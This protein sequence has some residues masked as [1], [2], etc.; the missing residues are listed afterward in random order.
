MSHI[1]TTFIAAILAVS[2]TSAL[3]EAGTYEGGITVK[4]DFEQEYGDIRVTGQA[5]Y[6]LWGLMAFRT[7]IEDL[8]PDLRRSRGH[9]AICYEF[10]DASTTPITWVYTCKLE[11]VSFGEIKAPAVQ[12]ID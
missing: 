2:A 9:G 12:P 7:R 11:V 10:G 3:A 5:A 4:T 6:A 1:R 8:A